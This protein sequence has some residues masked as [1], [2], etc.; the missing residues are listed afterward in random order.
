MATF[1]GKSG[2]IY[3][4]HLVTLLI[5]SA[6]IWLN[7]RSFVCLRVL[8][9]FKSDDKHQWLLNSLRWEL[10]RWVNKLTNKRYH[11]LTHSS[12][13]ATV[14]SVF[15]QQLSPPS[16]SLLLSLSRARSLSRSL[17]LSFSLDDVDSC[18]HFTLSR[19][20]TVTEIL[21]GPSMKSIYRNFN[22]RSLTIPLTTPQQ[23]QQQI[24][25]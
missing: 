13:R 24:W 6:K 18:V 15:T 4:Y 23:Q 7:N 20:L 1:L 9:Q 10:V 8:S 14:L 25:Y 11:H 5:S 17:T 2:D 21:V 22:I 3:S 19:K 12:E 16:L